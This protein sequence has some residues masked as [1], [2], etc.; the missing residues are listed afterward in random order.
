MKKL[1]LAI[2][3]AAILC[4]SDQLFAQENINTG[5]S[6]VSGNKASINTTRSN[7][8]HNKSEIVDAIQSQC[9]VSI[10]SN[11]IGCDIVF[12]NQVKSPRDAASGLATGKR[13]PKPYTFSV[14]S[15]DNSVSDVNSPRDLA[16]GQASGKRS[17]GNPIGGLT[18]KGG[19]N[20]G[21]NQFNNL[22]VNNGQFNLPPDCPE[23]DCDLILSW[24]WGATNSGS[25]KSY[26][27]C[28]FIL[29]M[30]AGA[31]I[32]IKTKGTGASNL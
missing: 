21:G 10:V 5:E 17:P 16:T 30:E 14:S 3:F 9:L 29:T 25:A 2:A 31:C 27:Q 22:A 15:S 6:N 20:P 18:I 4:V 23:G 28:H 19:K 7:I 13:M 11:E 24:S 1:V 8:K 12:S 32:A 26:C